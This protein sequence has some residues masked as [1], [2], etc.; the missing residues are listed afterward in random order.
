MDGFVKEKES[1]K[2]V[3]TGVNKTPTP[4]DWT[5]R[6]LEE[7]LQLFVENRGHARPV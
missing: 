6:H 1:T 2:P 4:Q 7:K 5:D 3:P